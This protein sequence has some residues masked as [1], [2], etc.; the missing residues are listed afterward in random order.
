M[1]KQRQG[2][3]RKRHP[4]RAIC[5]GLIWVFSVYS[6]YGAGEFSAG[7][8]GAG[9]GHRALSSW[10]TYVLYLGYGGIV[11]AGAFFVYRGIWGKLGLVVSIIFGLMLWLPVGLLTMLS[12]VWHYDAICY[13]TDAPRAC[14]SGGWRSDCTQDGDQRC[15]ERQER[16]CRLGHAIACDRLIEQEA[17]SED[18][19]CQALQEQCEE[20]EWCA[21]QPDRC[22]RDSL[23]H[24]EYSVFEH[25][26]TVY[27]ERCVESN[28]DD[29][30]DEETTE[31]TKGARGRGY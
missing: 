24:I 12:L 8:D 25:V 30:S 27:E 18:A 26:C 28:D 5:V 22:G 9:Y 10:V 4:V 20:S 17:W 2:S 29:L 11:A 19:V 31:D 23:P 15:F 1:A 3:N 7:V 21:A 13:S 16:A 6:G 14:S